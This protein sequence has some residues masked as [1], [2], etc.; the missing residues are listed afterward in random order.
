MVDSKH[1]SKA[2]PPDAMLEPGGRSRIRI[3]AGLLA[4][5]IPLLAL[6]WFLL[7]SDRTTR[8]LMLAF[9]VMVGGAFIAGGLTLIDERHTTRQAI[10]GVLL[11]LLPPALWSL[12]WIESE[13]HR[14]FLL[15]LE[16]VAVP[17][18]MIVVVLAVAFRARI[19]G[20]DVTIRRA[21]RHGL[22]AAVVLVFL[23]GPYLSLVNV[24]TGRKPVVL[25]GT[26]VHN[27]PTGIGSAHVVTL[28]MDGLTEQQIRLRVD[29]ATARALKPGD[30][31]SQEMLRGGLGVAYRLRW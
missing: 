14:P 1:P 13:F 8:D 18:T 29:D 6:G 7:L 3:G 26:V 17:L 23:S 31:Y 5:V 24:L 19:F 12:V 22:T 16:A 28:A 30:S 20:H 10:S 21:L 25:R 4:V 27:K 2:A 11:V 15:A 9:S